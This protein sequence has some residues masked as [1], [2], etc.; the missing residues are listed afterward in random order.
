MANQEFAQLAYSHSVQLIAGGEQRFSR[1]GLLSPLELTLQQRK[2]PIVW[3]LQPEGD[4]VEPSHEERNF[5]GLTPSP[6][7]VEV[8]HPEVE[9]RKTGRVIIGLYNMATEDRQGIEV[10]QKTGANTGDVIAAKARAWRQEK[11]GNV[12]LTSD[13][14]NLLINNFLGLRK[15]HVIVES[16]FKDERETAKQF[17]E[18][19]AL[20]DKLALIH[21]IDKP[22][23]GEVCYGLVT[24]RDIVELGYRYRRM[25]NVSGPE[26]RAV[27]HPVRNNNGYQK[28][29]IYSV[30]RIRGI[31][32]ASSEAVYRSLD[33][34]RIMTSHLSDESTAILRAATLALGPALH[35]ATVGDA[36]ADAL[37]RLFN[38]NAESIVNLSGFDVGSM[39]AKL[40]AA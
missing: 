19:S 10:I 32:I 2:S 21:G 23:R 1:R 39:A 24:D 31:Y 29:V 13:A 28:S 7:L 35:K 3:S 26:Y 30:Q 15:R 5:L 22:R 36:N 38:Y 18:F 37:F 20:W 11:T 14:T 27:F 34:K 12:E 25:G 33:G 40:D 4:V 8:V 17:L 6:N 16:S 9:P